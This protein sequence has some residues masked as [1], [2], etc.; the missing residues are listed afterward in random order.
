MTAT[1]GSPAAGPAHQSAPLPVVGT[2]RPPPSGPL[3]TAPVRRAVPARARIM[4]W[5]LLLM[6]V[7]SL[8]V[9][10]MT[11]N[12]L[13]QQVDTKVSAVL[14]QEVQEL[15]EVA[16]GGVDPATQVPFGDV[17]ELLLDHLQRRFPDDD[18]VLVG[19]LG[20]PDDGVALRQN[21]V[22]PFPLADRLDV[23]EPIL[24]DPGASGSVATDA[25]EMRW[26][27]A[28][29]V[30]SAQPGDRGAFVV[31]YLVDRDRAE[32]DH[33][34]QTLGLVGLLGLLFAG[35]AAWAV[36]GRI[37]A[38]VRLVRQ[39]AAEVAEHD[40]TRR[41]PVRG[42]DDIAALSEQF[43]ALLDRLE[44]AFAT[45]RQF[46]DDASAELRAPISIVRG[47]LE[48]MGDDPREREA[49]VQLCTD[50]LDRMNRI[51]GDLLVLANAERPD[52][53]RPRP[54]EVAELTADVY[55]KVRAVAQR[56]WLL[57]AIGEGVADLDPERVTQAMVHLAHNAVQH[58]GD[59]DDVL[60]GSSMLEG[61]V[62]F[63][64]TDRGPG[65]PPEEQARIF[66]RFSRGPGAAPGQGA[67]LGLS[68]VRAIAEAHG[69]SVRLVSIPGQG[70]SFGIDLPAEASR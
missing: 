14:Q 49:V 8:A 24:A 56:R 13:M 45:Q 61:R 53:V 55:G 28:P 1:D 17:E 31:G 27:K 4:G 54:V 67:G 70:S 48:L 19:W 6:A 63:W 47:H 7:V 18:E 41:L 23:L 25:G 50:E 2:D 64:V 16:D 3:P 42:N 34:I 59:G 65:V 10:V 51:V 20:T 68:I 38:P 44:Q 52:F 35:V 60:I 29:V 12:L 36:A 15:Q 5:I 37:L 21:R 39:S 40:L 22:E 30:H 58:T 69:G 9:G 43:N 11:R 62:A 32:V 46:V 66:D 57:E 33:A 26:V